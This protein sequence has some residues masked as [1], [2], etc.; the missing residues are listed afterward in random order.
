M[1]AF[2]SADLVKRSDEL[3]QPYAC[4][5]VN[6]IPLAAGV[7]VQSHVETVTVLTRKLSGGGRR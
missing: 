6:T 7:V 4:D 3:V 2:V 5:R 1:A